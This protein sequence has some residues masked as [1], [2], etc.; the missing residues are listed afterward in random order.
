MRD[1]F[2]L[3]KDLDED[4]DSMDKIRSFLAVLPDLRQVVEE[5]VGQILQ[6]VRLKSKN[7]SKRLVVGNTHLFYHPLA[8]HVRLMQIF[9]AC[10]ML[11]NWCRDD[12]GSGRDQLIF[13]GDL[14][15]DPTS[16]AFKLLVDRK[17]TPS[18]CD[19]WKNLDKYTWESSESEPDP[20]EGEGC[21]GYS[22]DPLLPLQTLVFDRPIFNPPV[23]ELPKSFPRLLSAYDPLPSFTNYVMGFRKTLDYIFVS[24]T[25][26]TARWRIGEP[27]PVPTEQDMR[28][29]AIPNGMYPSDHIS[30]ACDFKL[31][32]S[33]QDE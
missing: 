17:V 32:D 7:S 30:I 22:L 27:A 14:N 18:L 3:P 13:C 12:F 1:L 15:S 29:P 33:D 23:I 9:V 10:K 28:C 20:D 8:D 24:E 19:A 31:D 6:V 26:E 11:D 25:N 4:W 21:A 2:R 16:G 5:R